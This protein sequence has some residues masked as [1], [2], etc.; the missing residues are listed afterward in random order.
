MEVTVDQFMER[1]RTLK[2]LVIGDV[3]LDRYLHGRVD[4]ISPEA[5]VPVVELKSTENRPGGA[6][7]VAV[8]IHAFG[9]TP[10][11]IGVIGDDVDGGLLSQSL[12]ELGIETEYLIKSQHRPTTVKSRILSGGQQLLRLDQEVQSD[13]GEAVADSVFEQVNSILEK[14][15]I[16][17]L[18]FQDYNKGV[19]TADLIQRIIQLAKEHKIPVAVD[20]KHRNFFSYCDIQLFKPNL[21]E[22]ERALD[23]KIEPTVEVLKKACQEMREK[24]GHATTLIT[25]SDKGVYIESATG[26]ELV[27]TRQRQIADVCGA[28]DTVFC[29]AGLATCL[30]DIPP[31]TIA[32]LSNIAGGQVCE[33]VGVVS[34]DPETFSAELKSAFI[35]RPCGER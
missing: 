15:R 12:H 35:F 7:N 6:A 10:Y 24:L 2:V 16:D 31:K 28:G 18:L 23:R 22:V 21:G 14:I 5:P 25:L 1:L 26:G 8:N 9:A 19:L 11:L 29:I 4:R 13:L 27:P 33:R 3:M 30:N 32:H 20:P 34:I 17:V